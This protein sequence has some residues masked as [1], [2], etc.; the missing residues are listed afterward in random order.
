VTDTNIPG[1]PTQSYRTREPVKAVG[2]L[3]EW[4]AHTPEQLQAMRDGFADL[5]RRG[6]AVIYD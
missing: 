3:M 2:E 1:N 4:V 6:R 5:E